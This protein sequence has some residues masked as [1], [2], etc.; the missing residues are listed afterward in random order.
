MWRLEVC[1]GY[2]ALSLYILFFETCL[3]EP[4]AHWLASDPLDPS[5]SASTVV[6][7]VQTYIASPAFYMGAGEVHSSLHACPAST[8]LTDPFPHP[9]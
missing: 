2:L 9:C 3:T 7:R 6:G 5:L 8:L 1:K 4:E